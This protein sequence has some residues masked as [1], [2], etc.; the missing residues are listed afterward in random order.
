MSAV[1]Q[2]LQLV[3]ELLQQVLQRLPPPPPPPP[4]SSAPPMH[5]PPPTSSSSSIRPRSRPLVAVVRPYRYR[6]RIQIRRG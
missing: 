4:A 6:G 5:S 3:V 1:L 2:Q